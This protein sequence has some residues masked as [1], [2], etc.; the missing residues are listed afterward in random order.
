MFSWSGARVQKPVNRQET[1]GK[2]VIR[3]NPT[4]HISSLANIYREY[5]I[6][7]VNPFDLRNALDCSTDLRHDL[8][9]T[10]DEHFIPLLAY[11]YQ[12]CSD[13]FTTNLACLGIQEPLCVIIRTDGRWQLDNGHHRLAWALLHNVEVPV[14]FDDSGLDDDSD[15]SDR[16][17]R[18]DIQTYH[19][20][21]AEDLVTT[22]EMALVEQAEQYLH[23]T[24]Q[25]PQPRRH[26]R[27]RAGD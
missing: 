23:D 17:S 5:C 1:G 25:I 7:I 13:W 20:T 16:V 10:M 8:G 19:D 21:I 18:T 15:L 12:S 24:A 4:T 27:H 14:I 22:A 26:G 2:G 3:R 9:D 11:K 6:Q